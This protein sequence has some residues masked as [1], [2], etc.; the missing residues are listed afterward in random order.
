MRI[1]HL[2]SREKITCQSESVIKVDS[3]AFIECVSED[4]GGGIYCSHAKELNVI[5]CFFHCCSSEEGGSIY[6]SSVYTEV[7]CSS[8]V[9]CKTQNEGPAFFFI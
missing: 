4:K 9:G 7:S 5:S 6:S 2:Y 3:S 8:V 1:S